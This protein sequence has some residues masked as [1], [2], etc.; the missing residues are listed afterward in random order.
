[1]LPKGITQLKVMWAIKDIPGSILDVKLKG[2]LFCFVALIG[3]SKKEW[4]FKSHKHLADIFGISVR[5]LPDML[6][7]L[8]DLD[9]LIINRPE[10]YTKG[11]TNEYKLDYFLILSTAARFREQRVGR[12]NGR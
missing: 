11:D 4:Y 5:R 7:A 2:I 10:T 6:N 1:M 12:Q 3:D 8:E 9:F